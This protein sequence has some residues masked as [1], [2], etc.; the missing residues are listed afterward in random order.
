MEPTIVAIGGGALN[1]DPAQQQ[2]ERYILALTGRENPRVCFIPTATGDAAAGVV[3]FYTAFSSEVCRPS[4]LMLIDRKVTDLRAF[5]L[6]KDVIFAGGGNTNA[7]LAIWRQQG[8]DIVL[9]EA[10]EQ[11]IVLCGSS[12]G[13]NCWHEASSTDSWG[14]PLKPLLDGLGFV[15]GSFCP[16][17]DAEATRRPLYQQSVAEGAIPPGIACDNSVAVR[18]EGTRVAEIV[19]S[20]EAARAYRL[21]KTADGFSETEIIPRNLP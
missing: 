12:A 16:H 6:S 20:T 15:P 10:W 8:L 2:I 17:Y 7:M 11:G 4:H 19:S 5:L 3:R 1:E 14:L 13:A 21:E 18:Y 9:R